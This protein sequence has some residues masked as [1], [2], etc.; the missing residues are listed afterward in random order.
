MELY[1]PD[2]YNVYIGG[3]KTRALCTV[4]NEPQAIFNRS[5]EIR[6]NVS[7]LGTLYSKKG[8]NVMLRNLA[9]NPTIRQLYLWGNGTLSN[10]QFGTSGS[11]LLRALWKE[12]IDEHG[13]IPGTDFTFEQEIDRS[14]I[15][16]IRTNVELKD[17]SDKSIDDLE[18]IFEE[19][20]ATPAAYM[21]PKQFEEPVAVPIEQF[22]SEMV[23]WLVREPTIARAWARVVER[24][25]RYGVTKKTQYGSGQRELMGVTWVVTNEDPFEPDLSL[26]DNWPKGLRETISATKESLE[27]YADTI[28]SP[29]APEG[30]A[31]TYGNRLMRYP[32]GD[33]YIDQIAD[34]IIKQLQ[35]SPDTRRA[36]A[37][38]MVPPIDWN[39]SQPPCVTQVQALQAS[40]AVH[41]LVTVRSHDIFKSA[42][43]N[44]FGLRR[45]QHRIAG[46]TGFELGALQITSQ[47]AH[48]YEEDWEEAKKAARCLFWER[49][50]E[51]TFVPELHADPRGNVVISI[52]GEQ[53]E[54][55]VQ[56]PTGDE[57]ITLTGNTA[58]EL[59]KRIAQLEL[60]SRSD[61]LVDIAMELQ[62]AEIALTQGATFRQDQPLQF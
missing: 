8:M 57:L 2:K 24:I 9:L 60:I 28:T 55:L 13:T 22:P 46:E 10:T 38:T 41:L 12:G 6:E 59:S 53:L 34:V 25:M 35:N 14:V 45:L 56:G 44:A 58:K 1:R 26:F 20:D 52:T 21:D 42:I 18:E 17:V 43:A 33:G 49:D 16:Q 36:T 61:H 32:N 19:A 39:N 7:I 50:P 11:S 51:L 37:T 62:K 15:E 31:Y 29:E 47:S 30:V 3:G 4:W 5:E 40:G 48:I 27:E 54:A 23:G